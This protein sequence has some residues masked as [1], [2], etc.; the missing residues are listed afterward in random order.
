MTKS[1]GSLFLTIV[2]LFSTAPFAFA[3][4]KIGNG[5]GV[6]VCQGSNLQVHDIMFMDVFEARREYQLTLP[7][8]SI[9]DLQIVK[10]QKAWIEKF[11]QNPRQITKYI[12]YVEEKNIIWIED[13]IN[14]I[15]DA[16]NKITPHPS[17]CK[18]GE[19]VATQLVNF[20]EDFRILIRR[21]LFESPFMSN[22]EKAAVYL[23]EGIYSYLRSE[24]GDSTSVRARAI[25]GHLLSNLPDQDKVFEI[26]KILNQKPPDLEEPTTQSWI[27]GIKPDS[28]SALYIFEA[29]TTKKATEEVIKA[30]IAGERP[31]GVDFPG[32]PGMPGFPNDDYG[33]QR[34]CQE[35]RVICEAVTSSA[36]NKTC[37]FET[38]FGNKTYSGTGRT[39]LEAQKAAMTR[40]LA[41]EGSTSTCYSNSNMT[42]N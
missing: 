18:Q 15:P 32:M 10:N 39:E 40:C 19:W 1:L 24:F 41:I 35:H 4:D 29:Q 16:A 25:V 13:I 38:S 33:P 17:T 21:D 14:L 31:P 37:S 9:S 30:C 11:L 3:A 22:L 12:D 2:S 36:K 7:E 6:W 26:Q 23:H 8:Q 34:N 28:R 5:G 42:C 20:T 27:C